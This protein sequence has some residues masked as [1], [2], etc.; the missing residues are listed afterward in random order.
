VALFVDPV[1]TLLRSWQHECS[2]RIS[3]MARHLLELQACSA[4]SGQAFFIPTFGAADGLQPCCLPIP[5]ITA[6]WPS[7]IHVGARTTASS[8]TSLRYTGGSPERSLW[9]RSLLNWSNCISGNGEGRCFLWTTTSSETRKTSSN[10]CPHWPNGT[11]DIAGH[12]HSSQR[13]P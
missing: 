2:S 7:N 9:L 12:L 4:L 11:I 3:E 13:R 10:F 8:A 5:G 6:R 1:L